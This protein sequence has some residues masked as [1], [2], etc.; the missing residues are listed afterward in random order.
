M[1][2]FK[3]SLDR[4]VRDAAYSMPGSAVADMLEQALAGIRPQSRSPS[5]PSLPSAALTV[6]S[7]RRPVVATSPTPTGGKRGRGR[8]KGALGKPKPKPAP[9]PAPAP[10]QP[11]EP[12][13]V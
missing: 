7:G 8:P 12:D 4:W 3:A 11:E 2:D 13:A 6:R 5:L 1:S 9:E 10:E